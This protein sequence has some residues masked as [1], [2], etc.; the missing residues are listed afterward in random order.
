M[1]GEDGV[2]VQ[3]DG[4]DRQFKWDLK[5]RTLFKPKCMSYNTRNGINEMQKQNQEKINKTD[6][7][8]VIPCTP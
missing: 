3:I 8:Q 5:A 2:K 1:S 6:Y 7:I 4:K